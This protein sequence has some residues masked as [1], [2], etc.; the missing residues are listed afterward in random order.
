MRLRTVSS[1]CLV[2]LAALGVGACADPCLDDG[3]GQ[4]QNEGDCPAV[5][6]GGTET[7]SETVTASITDTDGPD[8]CD[9]GVQDGDETDVD[10]G[11]S[12]G[13]G[14]GDGEGCS[15]DD[16]CQSGRCE[17]GTCEPPATCDDGVQNGDETDVDCGGSCPTGCDDG[18]GCIED[19]DCESE[20][21]DP[22]T[23]TCGPGG[24]CDDDMQNGDETDVD[25][26]GSCPDDCDV[27]E[28]CE[29][30]DDCT[31]VLCDSKTMTC[32]DQPSCRNGMMDGEESDVDCGGAFCPPC[33]DGDTC[34]SDDD[35]ESGVCDEDLGVCVPPAC[36]DQT[37]NG[38][39]TDVDCGGTCPDDCDDGE[40]C[41]MDD[42]CI[43]GAC[44]EGK[45]TCSSR[46]CDDGVQNGDETDVDC[47]GSCPLDCDDGLGC[48]EG[49]DCISQVCDP[50]LMTC[51]PPACDDGVQNGDETDLDCGGACGATCETGEGCLSGLDCIDDVCDPDDSTCAPPLTVVAAPA[52]SDYAGMPVALDA[53]AMGGTGVYTYSWTP[54]EGLDDPSAEDPNA[55]PSGFITYTV[56][57]DDGVNQAQDSVTVVDNAPFDLQNN[58]TLYQGDFLANTANATISYS[59]GGTVACENGN[60]D[61]GLHLCESVVFQDVQLQGVLE[62]TNDDNDDDIIGMVW[63]AQNNSNFYSL[64]WKRTAQDFF[65]CSIPAGIVVKRVQAPDFASVGGN[66]VYCP[67]NTADSTLLLDPT[68]T[69][70]AGWVEGESYTV[71]ID[72]STAGSDVSVVRDSDGVVIA[73]FAVADA[74]F[75]SGAFGSTTISQAN[76]CVGPLGASC[77]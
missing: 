22:A 9:N 41:Q 42:D 73:A 57:V 44:D 34:D 61:F 37:Q 65:N 47:G 17:A 71:T 27:G 68:M 75:P 2:V 45:N 50:Q 21:C 5:T 55:A 24:A 38:D 20:N 18:E 48:I 16:D 15:D 56:T 69:T 4:D 58:C 74:T 52:C 77:L 14:C 76:A 31:T 23:M 11:G 33:E 25:C 10:C 36:D 63:G 8:H 35:C 70:T 7:D 28:G 6:G 62:V 26:G 59:Q 13:A 40:G 39:E 49:D 12:C 53:T 30:D 43:S 72:Y 29:G 46:A 3:L 51:T 19:D 67:N 1:S 60:N 32:I 66:D 64:T 54:L